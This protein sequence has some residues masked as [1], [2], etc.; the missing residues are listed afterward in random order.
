M[1]VS[2]LFNLFTFDILF[3]LSVHKIIFRIVNVK[4]LPNVE[5]NE[6]YASNM[7]SILKDKSSTSFKESRWLIWSSVMCCGLGRNSVP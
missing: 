1:E 6:L 7:S 3:G 4:Y 5:D 2:L